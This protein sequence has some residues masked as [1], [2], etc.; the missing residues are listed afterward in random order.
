M[1]AFVV[2]QGVRL[3]SSWQVHVSPGGVQRIL[4]CRRQET[5]G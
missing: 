2:S 4:G 3:A 1:D 5:C